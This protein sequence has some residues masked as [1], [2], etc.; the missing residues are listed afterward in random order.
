VK[1]C[2]IYFYRNFSFGCRSE[3]VVVNIVAWAQRA[4]PWPLRGAQGE[5]GTCMPLSGLARG[6]PLAGNLCPLDLDGWPLAF[7]LIPRNKVA[8]ALAT[9]THQLHQTRIGEGPQR[10]EQGG[11]VECRSVSDSDEISSGIWSGM[12][13]AAAPGGSPLPSRRPWSPAVAPP[14]CFP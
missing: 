6:R 3:E 4:R 5:L 7:H 9:W 14:C 2:R 11:K 12:T 8:S 13:P 10:Q 1:L